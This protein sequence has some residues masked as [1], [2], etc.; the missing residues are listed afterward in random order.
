[1]IPDH[2]QVYYVSEVST[3][4]SKAVE[5]DIQEIEDEAQRQENQTEKSPEN[6]VNTY[7]WHQ[8]KVEETNHPDAAASNNTVSDKNNGNLH[9]KTGAP[10]IYVNPSESCYTFVPWYDANRSSGSATVP[11]GGIDRGRYPE[12]MPTYGICRSCANPCPILWNSDNK[13]SMKSPQKRK[14]ENLV[15]E[16]RYTSVTPDVHTWDPAAEVDV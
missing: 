7:Q 14:N 15:E 13:N 5:A 4:Y 1:M 3:S 11:N 6:H 2:F 16:N 10:S 8:R 9:L 12:I